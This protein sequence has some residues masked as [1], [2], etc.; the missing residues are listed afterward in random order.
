M[1]ALNSHLAPRIPPSP[2][3]FSVPFQRERR[4]TFPMTNPGWFFLPWAG[5]EQLWLDLS[6]IT[7][8][9]IFSQY[10]SIWTEKELRVAFQTEFCLQFDTFLYL[11]LAP[12]DSN[13]H[14]CAPFSLHCSPPISCPSP[15]TITWLL[16]T[17]RAGETDCVAGTKAPP[18]CL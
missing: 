16:V 12:S 7:F 9:I 14:F 11:F 3:L 6:L 4:G 10:L 1:A 2:A 8:K 5:W 17:I 13:G 18:I 15:F